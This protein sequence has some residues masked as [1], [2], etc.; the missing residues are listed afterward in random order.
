MP[1][2][3]LIQTEDSDACGLGPE[4]EGRLVGKRNVVQQS[5]CKILIYQHFSRYFCVG[6]FI[7]VKERY[8]PQVG[9]KAQVK[10]KKENG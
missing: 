10:Q 1:H 2:G 6:T 7:S 9:K 3:K 5:C 8:I 4:E